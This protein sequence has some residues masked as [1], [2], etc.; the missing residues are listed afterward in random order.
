MTQE[1][2]F[3]I[4]KTGVNIYLTG[5]AGSG[6][7]YLLNKY[8]SYLE[9]HDISV[10]ITASTGIAATHMNGMT[11]HSW[12]GIGIRSL[13]EEKDLEQ[14][15]EKKYLWKRF[16]K[17]RVL[18]I[19]EVS[20]LHASQLDMV[21]RVCRRFKRND[22]PFGGLQI[23]LSGDF[24][25]LPPI[26]KSGDENESGM[27]FDSKA[28]DILNPAVCY[29]EEQHRQED[30][31][32]TE[33][34][35]SI[36]TNSIDEKHYELLRSRI[37]A[38]LKSDIKATK[39]YTHNVNVDDINNIELSLIEKEERVS[40][41]TS[42]GPE[43][44]TDILKKGCLAHDKL[45][46]KIGAEVMCIKNN[47]EEGYVNGSRGKIIEFNKETG[48]P[49]VELYNGKKILLKPEQWAIEEDGKVKASVSQIPLRLAWAITIHKSQGMSLDNA[50]IDLSRTFSYGMG[51][52]ALSRVRTLEGISLVGFN[53]ESLRVDPKVFEFDQDL[54]NQSFSN[55]L[56][57]RKLK[58]EEQIKLEEDFINRM[59]G[60]I[61]KG[62]KKIKVKTIKDTKIPSIEITKELLEQGK[63][64]NEISA[65]RGL[66]R[67]TIIQHL[68]DIV[69]KYPDVKINH[70][71]PNSK[72][73]VSVRKANEKLKDD[74]V[75]KLSPIKNILDKSGIDLSFE[76][77][78]IAKLF[79]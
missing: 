69:K 24:F 35:N 79:I 31:T 55:E 3:L 19:D 62:N 78:R 37:G 66:V 2:A 17:A 13:L 65:A 64:I 63:D 14:L 49:I 71:K 77:I 10:A 76:D 57:F 25:Q 15:E 72:N 61:K 39:L 23:I 75:G 43:M 46:L 41:M 73:I 11:I 22:K 27:I 38:K 26:N 4:M 68:E 8:I 58:N 54:K 16:D 59:G 60:S 50:E 28:W 56:L 12:S 45:K 44:L 29:I 47:F 30:D 40:H 53:N 20:M 33:I 70:I 48:N 6:K 7:T 74:E 1:Q 34:L 36:R 18:I 42:I 52:V 51:Y 5:S 32:L 21:E 9:S 67:S